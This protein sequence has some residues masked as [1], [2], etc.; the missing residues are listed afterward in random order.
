MKDG[1]TVPHI[2]RVHKALFH[3]RQTGW[4]GT[5]EVNRDTGLKPGETFCLCV[6]PSLSPVSRFTSCLDPPRLTVLNI[7]KG[8]LSLSPAALEFL[9][10]LI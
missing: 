7:F 10:R 4:I 8:M 5:V 3:Y 9:S 1:Q 2:V 6:Y